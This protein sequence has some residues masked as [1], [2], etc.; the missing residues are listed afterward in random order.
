M[1]NIPKTTKGVLLHN[2]GSL[3]YGEVPLPEIYEDQ[4]LI[5]VHSGPIHPFDH[6]IISGAF[7]DHRS[8]PYTV[9]SEGSGLVVAT[10]SSDKA[11]AL[12]NKRVSFFANGSYGEYTVVPTVV[13]VPLPENI[14]YEQG[15]L[16]QVNPLTVQGFLNKCEVNNYTAIASSAAASQL[17]RMLLKG[18]TEAGITVVNFVRR[19]GQVQVLKDL[20][21]KFVIN[22]GQ[23]GWQEEA[24]KVLEEQKVQAYFDALGGPDAGRIIDQLPD[25]TDV[26]CY[27]TLTKK[28][29]DL[30]GFQVI[31]KHITVRGYNLFDDLGVPETAAKLFKGAFENIEKGT[32]RST[33]AAK[34][35]QEQFEEAMKTSTQE[36][37]EGK[38]LIQN[39]NFGE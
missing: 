32:F 28:N 22:R 2:D 12:L 17:G 24:K 26:Y 37:T 35:S 13:V 1:Q 5:K 31:S 3:T 33:V 38:V 11:K 34:F 27:G 23:E 39:S 14:D 20:G 36:A 9:G 8:R 30:S 4:V 7:P 10:G 15:S 16:C 25:G 29:I 19:E 18:A 6:L 21:A